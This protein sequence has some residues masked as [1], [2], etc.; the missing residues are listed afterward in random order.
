MLLADLLLAPFVNVVFGA[1]GFASA[2]EHLLAVYSFAL[3]SMLIP[4][5]SEFDIALGRTN[6][7][8]G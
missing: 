7:I 6:A 8:Q 1:P 2:P 5:V 3:M 4:A